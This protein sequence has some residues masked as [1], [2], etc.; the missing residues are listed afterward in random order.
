MD[1]VVALFIGPR[2]EQSGR[3]AGYDGCAFN[4][5]WP[6]WGGGQEVVGVNFQEGEA[7]GR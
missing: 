1:E 3:A 5:A 6:L 7:T 2:R 4:S